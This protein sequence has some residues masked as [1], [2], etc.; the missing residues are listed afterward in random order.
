MNCSFKR[1]REFGRDEQ[2]S[3]AIEYALILIMVSVV[4]ISGLTSMRTDLAAT[5]NKV[6]S[7]L[8]AS[9]AAN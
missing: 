1:I 5:F 3:T 4:I 7:D 2:G 9:T 6:G 8:K